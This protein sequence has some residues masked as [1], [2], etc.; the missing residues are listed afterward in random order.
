MK[1]R[2]LAS[3]AAS[4]MM[5]I[6]LLL[7][8]LASV[9]FL[10]GTT[11]GTGPLPSDYSNGD[12]V[13]GSDYAVDTW[14]V[15]STYTMNG[16]LTIRAGGVVTVT[17]G[18]LVFAENI[19][20]DKIAGTADDRVYTLIIED[21]GKLILN[22]ST[23]TTNLN[24]LNS[25]P[26]LGVIVRNGGVLEAYDSVLSFPGH[27]VVDHS[28]LNLWRSS[29]TGNDQVGTY[30]NDTYFNEAIF[31]YA[32]VLMFMSST[33]NL[34]DSRLPDIYQTP[35]S[36]STSYNITQLYAGMYNHRY[37]FVADVN[38]PTTGAREAASYSLQRMPSAKGSGDNTGSTLSNLQVSDRLYYNVNDGRTM[39]LDGFDAGGLVFSASDN[40]KATLNVEYYTD[41]GFSS[42]STVQY[43][44]RNGTAGSTTLTFVNTPINPVTGTADEKVATATL[45]AMSSL[46][47]SGLNLGFANNGGK[48]LHINKV[49]IT[50]EMTIPTYTS[51]NL[52]G[53][54]QFTAV[55][56][57][58]GVDFS[59]EENHNTLVLRD[60]SMAYL[61]G[62]TIDTS[63]EKTVAP[64]E[65]QPA[66]VTIDRTVEATPSSKSSNDTTGQSI[67]GLT[68]IDTSFYEVA[69][70]NTMELNGFNIS[71]LKG[72]LSGAVL[73]L[74]YSTGLSYGL[75]N[76]LQWKD[77]G[78]F[79]NTTIRPQQ[80]P[81]AVSASFDLYRNGISTVSEV[82]N[83]ELRFVNSDPTNSVH[84]SKVSISITL[85]PTIYIYRWANV[86]V[87][88]MQSL[89]VNG[90]TV[91]SVLQNSGATAQYYTH[92]GLRTYPSNEVLRYLNRDMSNYATTD[93]EGKVYLPL[94]SEVLDQANPNPYAA[95][96]YELMASYENSTGSVFTNTTGL[97]FNPYPDM[98]AA[99]AWK[100]VNITMPALALELP[101]LM[102]L[103]ITLTPST[104]YEGESVQISAVLH[105]RGKT[106]ATKVE[107]MIVGYVNGS[108][109]AFWS[110][111]T[112]D[113][114]APGT[115]NDQALTTVTWAKIPKGLHTVSVMVDPNREISEESRANNVMS[116]Q[117]TVL[118]NLA[119]LTLTS[120]DITFSP[121]QASSND[122]VTA[123][124]YVNNTGRAAA[125]NATI[126]LYAGSA[127]SGGQ[128]IG[129][130]VVTVSAGGFVQTTFSWKP[131]QIGTYPVYVYV[132]ADR[133]IA[134][135]DYNNNAAFK[136]IT[137]TMAIDG[138]DLVI[139]GPQY[140]SLTIS[141]PNAFNWAYNVVVINNGVLTI[142]N[143]PFT[144]VQSS[145]YQN[146]IIVQDHG[147]LVLTGGTTL[148]SNYNMEL[149]LKDH[150]NL[151]VVNS[152]ILSSIHIRADDNSSVYIMSSVLGADLAAPDT[153]YAH[154]TAQDS[155][156]AQAWSSFG[157]HAVADVTN[158]SIASLNAQGSAV[159]HHYRWVKIMVLD[160]TG[161]RL[162]GAY[163]AITHPVGGLYAS[164]L[165][166]PDGSITF[167]VLT[168]VRTAGMA[169]Y[170]G[171]V[172]DYFANTTYTYQGH[173]FQGQNAM[174]VGIL[175][176]SEPL[177]RTTTVPVTIAVPGALPDLDPPI[178]VSTSTP[179]HYQDV[180]V[181]T[182]VSNVG[183][184]A[185]HNVLVMFND[186]GV[187]FYQYTIP[188]I[189][190]GET[191]SI[192]AIW[193]ARALGPHN[194]SV[195]IDPY[196]RINELDKTNN[197][198][199]TTVTVQGIADL[200]V[201]K[202]EVTISP[203]T[204]SRGQTSTISAKVW[205]TGDVTADDVMVSFFI[206]A[207]GGTSRS[208]LTNVVIGHIDKDES[209]EATASWTPSLP[210]IYIIEIVVD[211]NGV[212]PEIS[213]TNNSVSLSQKVLNYADLR[214]NYVVFNPASPVSIGQT[215]NI[216]ASVKNVGEVAATNVVVNFYL[217]SATSGTLID[218]QAIA[219]I[220]PDQTVTVT[221]HWKAALLSGGASSTPITVYVDPDGSI[222]EISDANNAI[223]QNLV[224]NDMRADLM[225]VDGITVTRSGEALQKAGQGETVEISATAK[226][227]G[228]TAAISAA[229]HFYAVDQ[230]N[231]RTF[232]GATMKNLAAG[233]EVTVNTTWQINLT[234]GS[235]S[236]LVVANADDIVD[237][238]DDTNNML[239]AQFS[240]D[241]PN[242]VIEIYALDSKSYVPGSSIFVT[243]KVFNKNTTEAIPGVIVDVWL[244]RNGARVGE[245]FNGTTNAEGVFAIPLYV[246]DG[247]N[248]DYQ[249]HAE[250]S[251]G[252]KVFPSSKNV[253]I[254]PADKV[255]IPWY[256][257]LM[258]LAVIAAA[259]IL[260]SAWLYKYGLGKMVECGE[261]GAL[262][263]E[264]SR[265]C[266]KCGVEFE[267]GT[268]KCSECGAWIPSNSAACPECNAKFISDAIEE[269]EDA[270]LK[271]MREQYDAYVDTFREEAKKNM[272][273]KYSDSKFQEWFK[274]QPSYVSFENWLSQEE[275]KRK[276]TGI[277]C[278][279][280]GTLNPRGSPICH[281]CGTN[282]EQ[283]K[284]PSAEEQPKSEAAPKPL[285][286]IVRRPVERKA[287]KPEEL[288]PSE[289]QPRPDQGD[290]PAE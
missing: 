214:P 190:P 185:A 48:T 263:P 129:S 69:A 90:A 1:G 168:D 253:T 110:N 4:I 34:Y 265:R 275:E 186:T 116:K 127:S 164:G 65:R 92:D 64:A 142:T 269:E 266:P 242:A 191:V 140:P 167:R 50:F 123:T 234:M 83:L 31:K 71:D 231:K 162:P 72:P 133:S 154:V 5:V 62:V 146:R 159:I 97:A 176:Y 205:N 86:T 283:K 20:S 201:Q 38:N 198:N 188:V 19:G 125:D 68:A 11:E 196:G 207:P 122:Q 49:W 37:S 200:T 282:L 175:G 60:D 226:N 25:F 222:D 111:Q 187:P 158:V 2:T 277:S 228:S 211:G 177:S 51:I 104:V 53:N 103:P 94:L 165:T 193:N 243:G 39:W 240:I 118:A 56:S 96:A 237:D 221:G 174:N 189:Q 40:V 260:F 85:S 29:I 54:T 107:V 73:T 126:S 59:N 179:V 26:S 233:A 145:A 41:S 289:E 206:T 150:A 155:T 87:S 113:T 22:N 163:V 74:T 63:A 270:Y 215:V 106:T 183:V 52:A 18:G 43:Q 24:Q 273:K 219:S 36:N 131:S 236:L 45:P 44:Y 195:V 30:C 58:L 115:A 112:V 267:V 46:D 35:S 153:S 216:E 124:I 15:T 258:I 117:F 184:V 261:C 247:S 288:K 249:I 203:T 230:N 250:S 130:T 14:S 213:E 194:I 6:G 16:N 135:Y 169:V 66:F 278:P 172:G 224:I 98:S 143:T 17:G 274:K 88:D 121:Q 210:G 28:K 80:T 171:F 157:G 108:I 32:P 148:N 137:V 218:T 55:N 290:K 67:G 170:Q 114:I 241:A 238:K 105:N 21:G 252:D 144:Q 95:Y 227:G 271:K 141:G 13:I 199:Y 138:R 173:S 202:S 280:C 166:G 156:F 181:S 132:N 251:M 119:E 100:A 235:Y 77:D 7:T 101:D 152:N 248:G 42:S 99:N 109:P 197:A 84:I 10:M 134:E 8:P 33:V 128:F 244:E 255:G 93:N 12:R 9:V 23:L 147:T 204:P 229:F 139:G 254:N 81:T 208:L 136:S 256:I 3:R 75:G 192:S 151:T 180:T 276:F 89:P 268:A 102:V 262:I 61:Y 76:Y 27:L 182:T 161:E 160:G 257:Y 149:Y 239:T 82:K 272:G 245:K 91:T 209:G 285:R 217:G 47:L 225:F 223:S 178:T 259:I 287:A 232:I 79:R 264:S 212:I 220:N 70:G 120:T 246:P 284:E 281:K 279:S 78:T 57:Y 286:R